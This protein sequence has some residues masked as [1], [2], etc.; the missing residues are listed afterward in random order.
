[1]TGLALSVAAGFTLTS[2]TCG[3]SLAPGASCTVGVVFA[4]A[5]A[6][7]QTGSLTVSSGGT[8]V[9]TAALAGTGFDFTVA[10]SASSSLTIASGQAANFTVILAPLGGSQGTFSL[11]CGSLPQDAACIFNPAAPVVASGSSGNV[12][13]EITTGSTTALLNRKRARIPLICG[14]ILLPFG[15]RKRRRLILLVALLLTLTSAV[16]SCTSSMGGTSGGGSGNGGSTS[17]GIYS[18]PI[19]ATSNS[20]QHAVTVTLTV[21]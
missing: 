21:D 7:L 15:W 5:S 9:A 18:I 1:M 13:L 20:V 14:L 8:T 10:V 11:T 16:T 17:P 4:P 2:N 3:P 6:I 19:T 12:A